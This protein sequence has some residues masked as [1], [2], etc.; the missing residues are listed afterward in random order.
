ML[1]PLCVIIISLNRYNDFQ[2]GIAYPHS[3]DIV[4]IET[5]TLTM[6]VNVIILL[7]M[8]ANSPMVWYYGIMYGNS[9]FTSSLLLLRYR[10]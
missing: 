9:R 8:Y 5:V 4:S 1:L 10:T 3:F 7:I 2:G 6:I